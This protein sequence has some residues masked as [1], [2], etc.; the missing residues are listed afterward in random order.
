MMDFLK[1]YPFVTM[2]QYYWELSAPKIRL[3]TYD[4]TKVHYLSEKQAKEMK[5]KKTARRVDDITEL[6]GEFG[7]TDLPIVE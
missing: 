2:E 5:V 3:M 4:A 7:G 6:M 1:A